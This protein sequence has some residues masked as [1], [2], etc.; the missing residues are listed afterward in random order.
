MTNFTLNNPV[1]LIFGKGTIPQLAEQIPEGT[2]VLMLYGGGSIMKN[3]VYKQVKKALAKCKVTE[4]GGIE[5]NPHYETCMKA[6]AVCRK[7][8]IQFLLA[9][10]GGSVLDGTKF[11]AAAVKFRGGDPWQLMEGRT[12]C[13]AALPL[14]SVMTL[15]ATGSEMNG[16]AVIS[17]VSANEKQ[18]L[19]NPLL[20]P[21]FSI[22]DPETTYTLPERQTQ[23]GIVDTYVHVM[24]QYLCNVDGSALTERMAESVLQTLVEYAPKVKKMPND[25][26]VR[27]ELMWCATVGLNGWLGCGAAAQDW[28]THMIGHE[29][30]AIYGLDHAR[31]LAI[32]MPAVHT[33]LLKQKQKRMAQYGRRVWGLN[34][35]DKVV[36]AEAVKK[37][38]AFF[39][40][41]GFKTRLRENKI[42]A[43]EAGPEVGR[44][45]A[46]R[47]L[48]LGEAHNIGAK[49]I[50]AI[51]KLAE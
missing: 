5:P 26:T 2:R 36:A 11:I 4:F 35:T 44:R 22:L 10:G 18:A 42:D 30:T 21:K 40:S 15:P 46:L 37:T 23:N 12:P 6:V 38:E 51:L 33:Y 14:G 20:Y 17:R 34:G 47:G 32:V 7:E 43:A 27:A 39:R 50:A 28:A 3:G 1:T 31:T 13:T 19:E 25:Y 29:L 8:K 16:G 41:V 45:I 48:K 24:E 9:V 49:E